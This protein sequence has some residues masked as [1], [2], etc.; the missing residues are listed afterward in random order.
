MKLNTLP[1]VFLFY[2]FAILGCEAQYSL[3]TIHRKHSRH[4]LYNNVP[5]EF[6]DKVTYYR[7]LLEQTK[8][9]EHSCG[10][11]AVFHALALESAM[12]QAQWNISPSESLRL[13]FSDEQ[14]Y[15][16][17]YKLINN[18]IQSELPGVDLRYGTCGDQLARA[19]NRHFPLLKDKLLPLYLLEDQELK[20]IDNGI[21]STSSSLNA[22]IF[23][24]YKRFIPLAK[25]DKRYVHF[26]KLQKPFDIVHFPTLLDRQHWVLASI[27]LNYKGERRLIVI[28]SCNVFLQYYPSLQTL[29]KLLLKEMQQL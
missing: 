16:H 2:T 10:Q 24:H 6:K 13:L 1:F 11:R 18:M 7:A 14:R 4:Y 26:N 28:D 19:S 5:P 27:M 3:P 12:N 8:P 29:I 21:S 23:A 22:D 20:V 25:S 15:E 9:D 17:V